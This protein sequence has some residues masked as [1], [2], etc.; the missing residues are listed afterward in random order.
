MLIS[1]LA[2]ATIYLARA[3]YTEKNLLQFSKDLSETGKLKNMAYVVNSVGASKSYGYGY[4]Y[5]YN[6]GYGS[7][8]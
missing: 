4:N 2:D 8:E 5:G 1:Q 6:Y 7:K 3:N